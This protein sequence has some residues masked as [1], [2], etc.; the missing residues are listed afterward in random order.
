MAELTTNSATA[1]S[2][3]VTA[4][5]PAEAVQN[6]LILNHATQL[7][8]V[9][10]D[11]P[12]VRVAYVDDADADF[13]AEGATIP[14]SDPAL[15]EVLIY[16]GKISQLVR[17]S[18]EQYVQNGTAQEMSAS[19][20]RAITKKADQAFIAQAAPTGGSVTPP[21]GVTNITGIEDGGDVDANLDG[22]IDLVATLESNGATPSGIILDPQ[23]WAT[24]RKLK[25]ATGSNEGLLG[26]GTQDAARMLLD[27][28]VTV[29]AAMS[30]NSGLVVDNTAIV[31]AVGAVQVATS[32]QVYFDS[33]S[34]A[35]RATWRLG[36]NIVKP[37]RVGK[38]TVADSVSE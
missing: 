12:A 24:L 32:D 29:S 8:T 3:D 2:P 31:S 6:A 28:P 14:D 9:E 15:N 34:I 13:T 33:D 22:L 30:A 27:L 16:T 11:A 7:G 35:V 20:S 21:A 1:W 37:E 18:R 17:L 25:T 26:A 38:F 36:W 4:F 10:G 23:A 19:V 5:A